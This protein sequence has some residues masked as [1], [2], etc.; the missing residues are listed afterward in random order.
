MTPQSPSVATADRSALHSTFV[1]E[2]TLDASPARVFAAFADQAAKARWFVG[3]ERWQSSDHRLDFRVGGIEHLRN[4]V[5]DGPTHTFDARYE[6]I[7][8][9]RRIVYT[10]VMHLDDMRISVSL[11]TLELLPSGAGTHLI[12]TEQDA[13]LDGADLPI[14]REQGTRELLDNLEAYLRRASTAA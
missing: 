7:V 12:L 3:P 11:A 6:D 14:Q 8:P 9:D 5:P 13:F 4:K 2:R 10:Y 1:I